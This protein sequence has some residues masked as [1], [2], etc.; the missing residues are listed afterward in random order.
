M[1]WTHSYSELF[2]IPQLSG[3][4]YICSRKWNVRRTKKQRWSNLSRVRKGQGREKG[5]EEIFHRTYAWHSRTFKISGFVGGER[6]LLSNGVIYS[7]AQTCRFESTLTIW[8]KPYSFWEA[9]Q[10]SKLKGEGGESRRTMYYIY[11]RAVELGEEKLA[12]ARLFRSSCSSR[13]RNWCRA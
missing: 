7:Y 4:A 3:I 11:T 8:K 1:H 2:E 13:E 12:A 5:I 10:D 9:I 6:A